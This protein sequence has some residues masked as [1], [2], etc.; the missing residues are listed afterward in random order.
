MYGSAPGL[1]GALRS[2][3]CGG[4]E[5]RYIIMSSSYLI[6]IRY[7]QMAGLTGINVDRSV[8]LCFIQAVLPIHTTFIEVILYFMHRVAF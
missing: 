5:V 2:E 4:D 7:V 6:L 3:V 1:V 8:P